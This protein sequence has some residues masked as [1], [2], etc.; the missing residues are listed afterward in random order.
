MKIDDLPRTPLAHLPT[1]IDDCPRLAAVF[2][3]DR[4]LIKRDDLTGLAM[5]GNK[6]RK[7]EFLMAEAQAKGAD[8]VITTGGAQSNH[9]RMTA[10]AARRLGMEPILLLTGDFDGRWQGNLLLDRLLGA[11][12]RW[13]DHR[14]FDD[15]AARLAK[16]LKAQGRKAYIVPIGGS[17]PLG[18]LGYALAVRELAGQLEGKEARIEWIVQASGS[19]GTQAGMILGARLFAPHLKVVGISV[20]R[21][22]RWFA[23]RIARIAT[24]AARLIGESFAFE[25]EDVRV[26][27]GYI[28]AAYGVPTPEGDE[29]VSQAALCEG[30]FFDPIYTGKALAGLRDMLSSGRLP[31]DGSVLFWHTGGSPALF[32]FE[33]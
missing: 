30:L 32:A 22:A 21:P 25:P 28:G 9:A 2:G 12:V 29:A 10:A 1:P 8:T 11:D 18:C 4:L 23:R 14:E 13:I 31:K 27:D 6:A 5:G 17:T 7:L 3:T 33:R 15:E 20:A 19:G 24:E 26:E 16:E